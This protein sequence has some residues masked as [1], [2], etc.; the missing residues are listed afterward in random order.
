MSCLCT[1]G[2]DANITL[3]RSTSP[4]ATNRGVNAHSVMHCGEG[5][6]F[7]RSFC[8][9]NGAFVPH[10]LN[11]NILQ[12]SFND[13]GWWGR[14]NMTEGLHKP[15]N[16]MLSPIH[17][18]SSQLTPLFVRMDMGSRYWSYISFFTV[19]S[20]NFSIPELISCPNKWSSHRLLCATII[21]L[22]ERSA[23]DGA[24]LRAL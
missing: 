13:M 23:R 3:R 11:R 12:V 5:V 10:R 21:L 9:Y 20:C 18:Y 2:P 1:W 17:T 22:I 24:I 15:Q 14:M 8:K 6:V 19:N 7:E 16:Q 4:Y